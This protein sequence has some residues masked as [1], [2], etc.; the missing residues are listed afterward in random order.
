RYYNIPT[1]SISF[2]YPDYQIVQIDNEAS[3]MEMMNHLV[4]QHDYKE[5]AI[6]TGPMTNMDAVERF[7]GY[8]KS[9]KEHG[10]SY[11]PKLVVAGK[12]NKDSVRFAINELYDVNQMKPEVILCSNDDM[13]IGA[14]FALKSR[15]II[16]GKDVFL[17]GFDDLEEVNSFTPPFTTIKMPWIDMGYQSMSMLCDRIENRPY[18]QMQKLRGELIIRESCGCLNVLVG[19][20]NPDIQNSL[21]LE[22]DKEILEADFDLW[23]KRHGQTFYRIILNE[24]EIDHDNKIAMNDLKK[25]IY[26]LMIAFRKDVRIKIPAGSFLR[27]LNDRVNDTINLGYNI[28]HWQEALYSIYNYIKQSPI[29]NEMRV[30]IDEIFYLA[31]TLIGNI[32][33]RL[34]QHNTFQIRSMYYGSSML[35]E[36]FNTV[37]LRS[38]LYAVLEEAVDRYELD[39]FCLCM[40]DDT[41]IAINNGQYDYP[42]LMT[43]EYGKVDDQIY[44]DLRYTTNE[45][46][47]RVI[48][49]GLDRESFVF[50]PIHFKDKHYGYIIT[51]TNCAEKLIFR[52]IREQIGN[53]LDRISVYAQLEQYNRQLEK[54]SLIDELT[55]LYNR[56]GFYELG[57]EAY[58][59][60]NNNRRQIAIIYGDMDGLKGIND[61]YGHHEG[62]A[63]SF[64]GRAISKALKQDSFAGRIGGDEFI[65]LIIN[66]EG[67]QDIEW[68]IH[69]FEE[70]LT[71]ENSMNDKPY[72]IA[73]SFGHQSL[74]VH[75]NRTFDELIISADHELYKE[76]KRR[77]SRKKSTIRTITRKD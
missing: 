31:N 6:I 37:L 11:N 42:E 65:I 47:P 68:F 10:I 40:F 58:A 20:L 19:E 7:E 52:T 23:L 49:E 5:I 8:K 57:E 17:T 63:I 25:V 77:K 22:Q 66:Y 38:E 28:E 33:K 30:L 9:L 60:A 62:Y 75:D 12:F 39:V 36:L 50:F 16:V 45:M 69:A 74:G 3:V 51:N 72:E 73:I 70:D 34:E 67:Q 61:N 41:V 24:I 46:I 35:I 53:T 14:F 32:S 2:D 76:K 27:L 13:A 44:K 64:I 59:E 48:A 29:N 4:L 15:G 55:G 54:I 56:R 71:V 1:V 26:E 21:D 43:L 18:E